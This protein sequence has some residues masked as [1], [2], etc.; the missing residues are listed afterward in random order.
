MLSARVAAAITAHVARGMQHEVKPASRVPLDWL[1]FLLADVTGG[2]G[3]FLAIYLMSSQQW[4]P[5]RIGFVLTVGGIATVIARG[6]AGAL[7]DGVRWKRTLITASCLIV[8]V[9]VAI[10]ALAPHF[11]P[12]TIAQGAIGLTDA[13]FPP[14]IAA[15]SLGIFGR[16]MFTRRIGRNEAFNHLGN[17]ASAIVA[18]LAGYL[19]APVAVLWV[20]VVLAAASIIASYRIDANAIDHTLA[21]GADDGDAETKSNSIAIMLESRPLLLF[22]ASITLFH[23]ANAAMLPLLGEKLSQG[24]QATSSLFMAACIIT[25]QVVMVPMALLVGHKADAW[26][27]K[28]L[29][30]VAFAVLPI[31]GLLYI[32]TQNPYVLVSIQ[33]LDGIGAGIFG[34]L[35]FVIIADLTKGSGHYNLAL[36]ASGACWGF[37]AALSNGAAGAVVDAAGYSAA[38]IFL[39]ACAVIALLIFWFGVPETRAWPSRG[40][41]VAGSDFVAPCV[42]TLSTPSSEQRVIVRAPGPIV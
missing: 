33:A 38:F 15:I 30:L 12:V 36:G 42:G 26:G 37:G 31:R 35:F 21:R 4:E 39:A 40:A 22:T 14:A 23:F 3:P 19:F 9:A 13:V 34:A 20:V 1:N 2:V 18:G 24:H 7:V 28:P 27:R 32:V 8:A 10:T 11:W 17:A 5:G 29:F 6:P 16:A 41:S 25:A